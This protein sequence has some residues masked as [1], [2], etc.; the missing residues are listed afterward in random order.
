[1]GES[2]THRKLNVTHTQDNISSKRLYYQQSESESYLTLVQKITLQEENFHWNL[3]F[4]ILL[5]ENLLNLNPSCYYNFRNFKI[6]AH[7]NKIKNS[8]MFNYSNLA[9]C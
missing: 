1:M 6:I 5:M 3:N 4:A 8:L 9:L 2:N 7:V